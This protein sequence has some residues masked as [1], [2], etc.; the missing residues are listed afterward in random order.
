MFIRKGAF[1]PLNPQEVG[2]R[3]DNSVEIKESLINQR[4]PK[5]KE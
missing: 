2:K 5:N 3:R 4:F 1:A